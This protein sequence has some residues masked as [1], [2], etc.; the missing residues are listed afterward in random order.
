MT[1]KVSERRLAENQ[2]VF[3]DYNERAQKGFDALNKIAREEGEQPYSY[4]AHTPLH[5]YCECSDDNCKKR[6]LLTLDAYNKA[7]ARRD[8][9]SVA[10]GHEIPALEEVIDRQPAYCIVQ[11]YKQPPESAETLNPTNLHNT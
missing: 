8:T 5:F 10:C 9:F 3:R 2:V 7:H 11:K 4:D 1:N 6:I